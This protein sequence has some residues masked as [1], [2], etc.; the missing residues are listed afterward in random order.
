MLGSCH[1]YLSF[2]T[3]LQKYSQ[4]K[5]N[6]KNIVVKKYILQKCSCAIFE[7]SFKFVII[8]NSLKFVIF[9]K[10]YLKSVISEYSNLKN[11]DSMKNGI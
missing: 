7:K 8:E 1:K 11:G 2:Q 4:Y 3:K 10:Y 5:K 9:I 6:Y